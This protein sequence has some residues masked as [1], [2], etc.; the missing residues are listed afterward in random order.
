[1]TLLDATAYDRTRARKRRILLIS[2]LVFCGV[3][4]IAVFVCWNLPAE[5]RVNRFFAA[6]EAKDFPKAFGIWNNDPDWQEHAQQYATADYPYGRF[7]LDWGG[8]SEYGRIISHKILHSSSSYG[9]NTLLAVEINGR[10]TALLALAVKKSTHTMSFPPFN[11]TPMKSGFGWTY[12]QLSY[13]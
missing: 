6:V 2:V 5:Y 13:R 8:A 9:N 11:L 10:N 1:M 4:S 7:V 12:W 3:I